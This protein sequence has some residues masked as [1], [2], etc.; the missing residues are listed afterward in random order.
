MRY[1]MTRKY[2]LVAV[3]AVMARS[4]LAQDG[5]AKGVVKKTEMAPMRDGVRLATDIYLPEGKGPWPVVLER[6]P[7][8]RKVQAPKMA[9]YVKHGFAFVVQDWRG[10]FDSEGKFTLDVIRGPKSPDDGY[11]TVEWIAKQ[12]WC[13]GKVGITGGSGPG[14][15]AKEA[16][17]GNPPHLIAAAT[18]VA[19]IHPDDREFLSGGVPAE[20]SDRW[21]NQRG[22]PQIEPWPKPRS[23]VFR[24]P[25]A[26][27]PRDRSREVAAGRIALLDRNGWYDSTCTSAFTDFLALK[28]KN[29]R[30]IM[31][32]KAHGNFLAGDLKY[33]LQSM[34]GDSPVDWF[35]YWLKGTQNGVMDS[36]PIRYFLMGD[37]MDRSAPGNVWK[38]ATT[39]PIPSTARTFYLTADG[40]LRDAASKDKQATASYAYDPKNPAPTIGGPNLGEN[41]GPQDQRKLRGRPDVAYFTTEPLANPLEITG[42]VAIELH[43]SADVTD[44]SF[45][46]KFIDI[47]PNGYES[48]QLDQAFMARFRDGFDK[49]APL[50]KGKVYKLKIDLGDIALMFNKG[51]RIGVIVTGGNSPRFEAHPNSFAAVMSYDNVPVAHVSIHTSAKYPSRLILPAIAAGASKDYTSKKS[52]GDEAQIGIN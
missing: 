33:P 38:Q 8:N 37:T 16:L 11:D 30:L 24:D 12:P 31:A 6:T 28:G 34:G 18:S 39:W 41:N 9:P 23:F 22:G 29:N 3:V 13:N 44:T 49:P 32:A 46:V 21:L 48:L 25:A 42:R 27:W 26:K 7:Y 43:F 14:I 15:A 47:Y 10:Q 1:Q 52:G 2:F 36:P 45:M 20:Q 4:A 50:E 35:E 17:Y 51:H 5:A 19:S 40:G